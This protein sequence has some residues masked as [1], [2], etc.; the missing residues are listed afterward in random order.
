M[1]NIESL[2]YDSR[3]FIELSEIQSNHHF[4]MEVVKHRRPISLE[5]YNFFVSK[6]YSREKP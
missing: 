3:Y 4:K 6:F 5:E 2:E 1:S